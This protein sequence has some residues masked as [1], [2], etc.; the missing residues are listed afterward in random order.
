[1]VE[2]CPACRKPLVPV[3]MQSPGHEESMRRIRRMG[4]DLR[5]PPAW[6]RPGTVTVVFGAALAWYGSGDL[7]NAFAAMDL[8]AQWCGF[9]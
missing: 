6:T 3:P 2:A 7:S 8:A 4:M 5:R 1:M 9:G